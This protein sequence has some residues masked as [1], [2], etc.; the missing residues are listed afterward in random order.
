M[1]LV[2]DKPSSAGWRCQSVYSRGWME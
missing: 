1:S 2:E